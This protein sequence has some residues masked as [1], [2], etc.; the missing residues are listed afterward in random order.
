MV[1]VP[2]NDGI[3]VNRKPIRFVMLSIAWLV[4]LTCK[5]RQVFV[6]D[7]AAGILEP[8]PHSNRLASATDP[9]IIYQLTCIANY[10]QSV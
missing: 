10:K 4:Q 9:Q 8:K 6:R 3:W 5:I 1:F 7:S 2:I